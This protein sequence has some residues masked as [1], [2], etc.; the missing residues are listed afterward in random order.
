MVRWELTA[1]ASG[2]HVKVTHSNLAGEDVARK[3][4]AGGWP[5]VL[6]KLKKFAE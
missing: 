3:D 6:E 2:T 1:T 4:Y 5:G